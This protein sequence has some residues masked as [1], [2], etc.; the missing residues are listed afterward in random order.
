MTTY[1]LRMYPVLLQAQLG[2]MCPQSRTIQVVCVR[3]M[4]GSIKWESRYT[5][6][7]SNDVFTGEAGGDLC[8]SGTHTDADYS[9]SIRFRNTSF[10]C[11]TTDISCYHLGERSNSDRISTKRSF[12]HSSSWSSVFGLTYETLTSS[13][14]VSLARQISFSNGSSSTRDTFPEPSPV[15]STSLSSTSYS[16]VGE[17]W[18]PWSTLHVTTASTIRGCTFSCQRRNMS[19]FFS[20][21]H[22]ALQHY[23]HVV[24][25]C[26]LWRTC[27]LVTC[28]SSWTLGREECRYTT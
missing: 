1:R 24:H 10:S 18:N 14:L 17:L 23:I 2:L 26:V 12:I 19:V 7:W 6:G 5:T 4:T 22:S 8:M 27:V 28:C 3:L 15:M 21:C 9:S 20:P 25:K 11:W 13:E 16:A